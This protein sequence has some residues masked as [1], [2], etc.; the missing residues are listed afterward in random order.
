M[1]PAQ[2]FAGQRDFLGAQRL[3]VGLGGVGA[4]GRALADVRL[5]DDQRGALGLLCASAMAAD[6]ASASCPS[7]GPITFQPQATKRRAVLSMN[8]GCTWPSMLMPL[9]SYSAISLFSFQAPARAHGFVADAFHQAAVAQEDV[10]VVVHHVMAFAVEFGG[11]QL[12][13][14]RHAHGIGN[15]LAQ[16]AGG[17]FHA[18]GHAHF[19]VAGGFAVQLA[20]VLQLFMGRS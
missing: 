12:F 8:Q 20:E 18:G 10:G 17:G 16:R 13:G 4:V 7:I 14:Q 2:G 11:Q 6:T 19:G 3:A 15:A 9:S 1:V 5:A